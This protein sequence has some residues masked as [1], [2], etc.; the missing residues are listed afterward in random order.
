MARYPT[1]VKTFIPQIQ[2][3]QVDFN[4]ANNVLKTKQNQYDTNWK[5]LNKLYGQ[6]Y[7][8]NLTRGESKE[9][10]EALVKQID[11]NLK[12]ISTMD[13]SLDQNVQAAKQI[14]QPFYEDKNLMKDIAWTKNTS[15]QLSGAE[16]LRNSSDQEQRARYWQDGVNAINY[17]IEEF[18]EMPY[19]Q[20][21]SA[22]N[23]RYTPYVDVMAKAE[24]IA[25]EFGDQVTPSFQ[26]GDKWILNTTNGQQLT[27]HLQ[28]LFQMRMANDPAI[29]DLYR[30]QAY[31]DRKNYMYQNA[32]EYGGDK[33]AAEVAYLESTYNLLK[34]AVIENNEKLKRQDESYTNIIK[35]LQS[36]IDKNNQTINTQALLDDASKEK[37]LND[38][39][40]IL[41]EKELQDIKEGKST[42]STTTGPMSATK[43]I[44][45]L[46]SRV[47][48]LRSNQLMRTDFTEAADVYAFRNFKQEL[49]VN[50]YGME[51]VK[52]QNRMALEVYT[53]D[54]QDARQR[55]IDNATDLRE[56]QKHMVDTGQ[57]EY[58]FDE[59]GERQIKIFEEFNN[60]TMTSD[61]LTSSTYDV[62]EGLRNQLTIQENKLSNDAVAGLGFAASL[63]LSE[64]E[65]KGFFGGRTLVEAQEWLGKSI[66]DTKSFNV[67]EVTE[68]LEGIN[69]LFNGDNKFSALA[70]EKFGTDTQLGE[71][72][73]NY[74]TN[75][76]AV[77]IDLDLYGASIEHQNMLMK[78][79]IKELELQGGNALSG[80]LI[81]NDHGFR[82]T[83]DDYIDK[84]NTLKKLTAEELDDIQRKANDNKNEQLD[85]TQRALAWAKVKEGFDPKA[86][87]QW[88]MTVAMDYADISTIRQ[89]DAR[90]RD[91][92]PFKSTVDKL[93]G[94]G[95][96][97]PDQA[98]DFYS[99]GYQK[100]AKKLGNPIMYSGKIGD[101]S[102]DG[103]SSMKSTINVHPMG[104][105][106]DNY[107]AMYDGINGTVVPVVRDIGS[108][109]DL[110][111][112]EVYTVTLDGTGLMAGSNLDAD[113]EY[114]DGI[115]D[116]QAAL[117]FLDIVRDKAKMSEY[118]KDGV[119]K[120]HST[121]STA[122]N[123]NL[124]AYT[125][126]PSREFI[127][128]NTVVR[129][130]EGNIK[131]AGLWEASQAQKMIQDPSMGGVGGVT[132]MAK[133]GVFQSDMYHNNFQDKVSAILK[134]SP[135][136]TYV[137]QSGQSSITWKENA[138]GV[139]E[140]QSNFPVLNIRNYVSN[141]TLGT[142][143]PVAAMVGDSDKR[144]IQ[145]GDKSTDE[146][147]LQ[148]IKVQAPMIERANTAQLNY[149]NQLLTM[150][151]EDGSRKYTNEQIIK[152]AENTNFY[153]N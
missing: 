42:L 91:W 45:L 141:R 51:R 39:A 140:A 146:I 33:N 131:E 117:N 134:A 97:T 124:S 116:R 115:T 7:Y 84:I 17:R 5:Q 74:K 80:I 43:D 35:K 121:V 72:F 32:G 135:N 151:N 62:G 21:Q 71:R 56:Y 142:S 127:K 79:T 139:I 15:M 118:K 40:L 14:F 6:I 152:A 65:Q 78:E 10:Q 61:P 83:D 120:V 66:S 147:T 44:A 105:D 138:A 36:N 137:V 52:Q 109:V 82:T 136:K 24:A 38:A 99:K 153:G 95:A 41:S 98:F 57:A 143:L 100:V 112:T 92:I 28:K 4:F 94:K 123:G 77:Q 25:K 55:K 110:K 18:K 101:G 54:R 73:A 88:A 46:R 149:V 96:P 64:E 70:K 23:A 47:D 60:V 87:E 58:F 107:S 29:Q 63:G 68:I 19:D 106:G 129:D 34:P 11:F 102:G 132:I 69:K 27:P 30:T 113:P 16:S 8:A 104:V 3:Y 53:Q 145:T 20:I 144:I 130:S 148:F 37:V 12:R 89:G 31:V 128:K 119:F 114:E 81:V 86:I 67:I 111:D 75:L 108:E 49:E 85:D 126:V 50:D 90:L 133:Q 103:I 93:R 9:K 150:T 26:D 122:Y 125:F 1:G 59:Y 22:S 48:S 76:N 13:L 2:P